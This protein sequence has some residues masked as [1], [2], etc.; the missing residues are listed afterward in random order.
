MSIAGVGSHTAYYY[1]IGMQ[2]QVTHSEANFGKCFQGEDSQEILNEEVNSPRADTRELYEAMSSGS[3]FAELNSSQKSKEAV[4]AV[5]IAEKEDEGEFLGLTMV[6]E[7]G[8]TVTYGMRAMLSENSTPTNPIV[9]VVSNLGGEK[10][11]YNVEVNKVDT[12]NASQLEMF[13]LL[14]Y[15][16]KKGITDGGT[17]GSFHQLKVY[18]VNAGMAGYCDSLSGEDTFINEKFDWP[19]IIEKMMKDYFEADIFKQYE[20][21][22]AL[23]DFFTTYIPEKVGMEQ[24]SQRTVT[25]NFDTENIDDNDLTF[26]TAYSEEG[27][28][29]YREGQTEAVWSITFENPE[30][31]EKIAEFIDKFPSDWNLVFAS[32]EDFW[33]DFLNDKIDVDSYEQYINGTNKQVP[34]GMVIEKEVVSLPSGVSFYMSEDTG[35]VACIDDSNHLP[36]RQCL[37]SKFLS[38]EDFVRCKELFEREKG[39]KTWEYKY[40][41]Y[42]SH[43]SFWDMYLNDEIDLSKLEVVD[44][45]FKDEGLLDRLLDK[46]PESVKS[47]W[48][49]ALE[50]MDND[51]SMNSVGNVNYFS[52][53]YHQILSNMIKGEDMTVLG[54]TEEDAIEFARNAIDNLNITSGYNNSLIH[55]REKES[56]FYTKFVLYLQNSQS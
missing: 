34:E 39:E 22:Q 7:E 28:T 40:G 38:K 24:F 10:V 2:R 20:D 51:F 9:Q 36:G 37:W 6:P 14:S 26:T 18:G 44:K 21:C 31:Y 12:N 52:V 11:I 49:K 30:Q 19:S 42:L 50:N 33:K 56:Q 23:I 4:G 8:Q 29:C 15:T 53:L 16:D 1:G 27:M 32:R 47:A 55:M 35:E 3:H 43:E 46:C 17:F 5:T 25:C 13:A 45:L 54:T 41:A 48:E